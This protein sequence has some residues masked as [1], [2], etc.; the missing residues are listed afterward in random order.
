MHELSDDDMMA[1]A[2]LPE[3]GLPSV[4]VSQASDMLGILNVRQPVSK[5]ARSEPLLSLIILARNTKGRK[6]EGV[7]EFQRHGEMDD[8]AP[9]H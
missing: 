6:V 4:D 5:N 9:R 3:R 1:V 8:K 7:T 2:V